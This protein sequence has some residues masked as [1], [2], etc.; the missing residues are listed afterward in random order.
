[1]WQ[2]RIELCLCSLLCEWWRLKRA[3]GGKERGEEEEEGELQLLVLCSLKRTPD[4]TTPRTHP[5]SPTSV[6]SYSR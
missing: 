5:L 6:Q 1:V 4:D 3:K 2:T